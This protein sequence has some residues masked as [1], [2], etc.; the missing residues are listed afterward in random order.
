MVR[1]AHRCVSPGTCSAKVAA[2]QAL[3]SQKNLRTVS[4]STTGCA[5]I[6]VSAGR[7][8]YRECTRFDPVPQV[9]QCPPSARGCAVIRIVAST[10]RTASTTTPV[11]CGSRA[12]RGATSHHDDLGLCRIV[13]D[14][15]HAFAFT[16][17]AP[18]P[19]SL[20]LIK[21]IVVAEFDRQEFVVSFRVHRTDGRCRQ[22][23]EASARR[24]SGAK[25]LYRVTFRTA[26]TECPPTR[27]L[28]TD[29]EAEPASAAESSLIDRSCP[30]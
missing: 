6:A 15:R 2:P 12:V 8:R 24:Q 20:S 22:C 29:T 27:N 13:P 17:S 25:S 14:Q 7:R 30:V 4:S 26:R 23:S 21:I 11:R 5:P 1:R 18:E 10:R 3:L 19:F 9:G 28:E 16:E